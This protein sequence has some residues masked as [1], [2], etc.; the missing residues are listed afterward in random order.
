MMEDVSMKTIEG[1]N[2]NEKIIITNANDARNYILSTTQKINQFQKD[3]LIDLKIQNNE[4][5]NLN[6]FFGTLKNNLHI[7][8][9]NNNVILLNREVI[10]GFDIGLSGMNKA[11]KR[12]N[13]NIRT[14]LNDFI[15][16]YENVMKNIDEYISSQMK[17]KFD[18]DIDDSLKKEIGKHNKNREDAF[19]SFIMVIIFIIFMPILLYEV[20]ILSSISDW[21]N[22]PKLIFYAA[23]K[24]AVFELPLIWIANMLSRRIQIQ[25]RICEEYTF[26]YATL[27]AYH[28]LRE[29]VRLRNPELKDLCQ[30]EELKMFIEKVPSAMFNNPSSFFDKKIKTQS[31]IHELAE[32]VRTL[33]ADNTR[34]LIKV[35][36]KNKN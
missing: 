8:E 1:I 23:L 15:Q 29:D 28:S 17:Q 25:E 6:K 12:M 14:K 4:L 16:K 13:T 24:T 21:S 18:T 10:N 7:N 2:Q 31:P 36:E 27:L 30:N 26:K 35:L 11:N 33:G 22:E 3:I 34:E 5:A 20:N 19:K 32:V 9:R